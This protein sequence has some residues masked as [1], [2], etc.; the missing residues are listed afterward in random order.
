MTKEDHI[1][2]WKQTAADSWD[3]AEYLVKGKHYSEA[4]FM[5]C[6]AI[7]KWLKA[8]WIADNPSNYPPRIHDLLSIYGE[9]DLQFDADQLDFMSAVNRWNFEG[10][11]PDYKFSLKKLATQDY[12]NKQ[13]PKLENLKQCLLNEL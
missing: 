6:L 7:K 11:Y 10:R 1:A 8:K 2:Y 12:M 3:S 9:T 5:Y 4:L 13:V